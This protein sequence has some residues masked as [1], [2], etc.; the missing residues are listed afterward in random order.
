MKN[1]IIY[2][3]NKSFVPDDFKNKAFPIG[4]Y[5]CCRFNN[6]DFSN[7]DLSDCKFIDCEFLGC[8]LSLAKL[9]KTVFQ[10]AVFKQSKMLGMHFDSCNE[11][12]LSFSFDT[13]NLSH[14]T[15]YKTAIKKT[16]FKDSQLLEVDFTECDLTDS[17]FSNCDLANATFD[18]TVIE[19]ADFRTSFNYSIDPEINRIKKA[20]FS[21]FGIPGLLEKYDI[22]IDDS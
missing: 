22:I 9:V 3:D 12:G 14:S 8:N 2:V 13:C 17:M 21:I 10:D 20:K 18:R 11:F 19:K 16:I 6:C 15:F 1:E 7:L 5:E 4:E